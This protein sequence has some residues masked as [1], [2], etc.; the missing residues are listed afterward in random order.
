MSE[1]NQLS[2]SA[3]YQPL[4]E[5]NTL[6]TMGYEALSRFYD[7]T[8]QTIAPNLVFEQLHQREECLAAVEFAAKTF[9]IQ[10]APK[11][12]RL[13]VNIDPH[14]VETNNHHMIKLLKTHPD[15]CVEIIENTCISDA[16][17]SIDFAN[18]LIEQNIG[19]ALDDVGAPHSMLSIELMSKVDCIKF[20]KHWLKKANRPEYC[21]LLNSL[22]NFAKKSHKLTILEGIET[23]SQLDFARSIDVDLVQGFIFKSAFFRPHSQLPLADIL[24]SDKF[25]CELLL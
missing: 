17:L 23:Q 1:L 25:Q 8:G 18:Q 7:Q 11:G 14:A 10:H 24:L 20:D 4:I 22:I 21:L 15:I 19:V 2:L 6:Q 5:P 9:Q 12:G 3:E 13:F 16:T